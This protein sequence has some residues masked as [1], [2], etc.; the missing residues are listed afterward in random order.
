MR[1]KAQNILRPSSEKT[2]TEYMDK[3]LRSLRMNDVNEFK[4]GI[5]Y[6]R[7]YPLARLDSFNTIDSINRSNY[8]HFKRSWNE[9][10]NASTNPNF[11]T[12]QNIDDIAYHFERENTIQVGIINVD[13]TQIDTNALRSD[14]PKLR[15]VNRK[16]QRIANKNPYIHKHAFIA[17]VMNST[18]INGNSIKFEFGKIFL[19]FNE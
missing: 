7:V 2:Y 15:I 16:V 9:L 10:Y 5:L 6:D 8:S 13:F 1:V 14:D 12:L 18:T 3:V 4:N 17:S 11:L 19:K